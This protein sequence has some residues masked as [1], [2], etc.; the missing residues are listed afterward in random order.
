MKCNVLLIY[1][2]SISLSE[3][4]F[5]STIHRSAFCSLNSNYLFSNGLRI[6]GGICRNLVELRMSESM[7]RR[8][9]VRSKHVE[10]SPFSVNL[11]NKFKDSGLGV[12]TCAATGRETKLAVGVHIAGVIES[13]GAS[14]CA[15]TTETI[16]TTHEFLDDHRIPDL[17]MVG[18]G[19]G[20]GAEVQ[21]RR[22]SYY[23]CAFR[24]ASVL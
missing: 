10:K 13:V 2:I 6:K 19:E 9:M 7:E 12:V 23:G 4:S 14:V 21:T 1:I 5:S 15:S 11:G 3:I 17:D 22:Q 20:T 18:D 8:V 24:F 16:R